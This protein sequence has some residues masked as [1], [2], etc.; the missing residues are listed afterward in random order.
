MFK[1]KVE[2]SRR[3]FERTS[4]SAKSDRHSIESY[5]AQKKEIISTVNS[6]IETLKDGQEGFR[7]AAEAV[8][9]SELKSLF[10]EFSIERSRLLASCKIN[11]GR[12]VKP[13]LK[14]A[15]ASPAR[16]IVRGLI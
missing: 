8:N 6:L 15:A 2:S 5:M 11:C 1:A 13:I 4:A 3:N 16:C 14:V 12:L 9:D 7:Q 10:S